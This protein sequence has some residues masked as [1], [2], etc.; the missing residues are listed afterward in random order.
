MCHITCD[1]I[2]RGPAIVKQGNFRYENNQNRTIDSF[3][4]VERIFEGKE[5]VYSLHNHGGSVVKRTG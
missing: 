3:N 2:C 4:V 5:E 1:F